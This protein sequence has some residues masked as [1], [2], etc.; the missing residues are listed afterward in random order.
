LD[1]STVR[2]AKCAVSN[3]L[4]SSAIRHRIVSG[5]APN[6]LDAVLCALA[7]GAERYSL[8]FHGDEPAV[9]AHPSEL[10]GTVDLAQ[11]LQFSDLQ[12]QRRTSWNADR[13]LRQQIPDRP[14]LNAERSWLQANAKF[15][16]TPLWVPAPYLLLGHPGQYTEGWPPADSVGAACGIDTVDAVVRA[17]VELAERDAVSIWWYN[18]LSRPQIKDA[19]KDDWVASVVNDLGVPVVACV[20]GDREGKKIALGTSGG[21]T[22][23]SAIRGALGEHLLCWSNFAS[24]S[25]TIANNRQ[26]TLDPNA[27]AAMRWHMEANPDNSPHLFCQTSTSC[28]MRGGVNASTIEDCR[29]LATAIGLEFLVFDLSRKQVGVPVARILVPGLCH[30]A[31][32]LAPGRLYDVPVKMGWLSRPL[33]ESEMSRDPYPF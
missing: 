29:T 19:A 12:Y 3:S 18:R 1:R 25:R 22:E 13:P 27:A 7:E 20:S 32:R 24:M 23:A 4:K 14:D 33:T 28:A 11:L 8:Q 15:S 9:T 26:H 2:T 31:R 30:T 10:S 21:R 17:F 16:S 5:C 6:Y